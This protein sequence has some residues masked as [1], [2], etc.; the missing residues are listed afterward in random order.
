MEGFV[1][2]EVMSIGDIVVQDI[3]F[4]EAVKEPGLV[5]TFAK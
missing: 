3:D 2:N 1:S 4:A 5:F